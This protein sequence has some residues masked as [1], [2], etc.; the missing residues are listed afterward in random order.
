MFIPAWYWMENFYAW[1]TRQMHAVL[2]VCFNLLEHQSGGKSATSGHVRLCH[3]THHSQRVRPMMTCAT[4]WHLI[5][6]HERLH[7]RLY[8]VMMCRQLRSWRLYSWILFTWTSNMEEGFIFTLYSFSRYWANF[9]LLSC[10]KNQKYTWLGQQRSHS[11]C[12]E[13]LN[14]RCSLSRHALS[15]QQWNAMLQHTD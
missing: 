15:L 14:Q 8:M 2:C 5:I 3:V 9:N 12:G 13:A 7:I 11:V 1:F 4:V 6:K 10:E